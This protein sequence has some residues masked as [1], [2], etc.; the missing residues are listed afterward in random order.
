MVARRNTRLDWF[1]CPRAEGGMR[2][3]SIAK[4]NEFSKSQPQVPLGEG[5]EI[6]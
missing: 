1:R 4:S 6:V 2:A 5:D 3:S